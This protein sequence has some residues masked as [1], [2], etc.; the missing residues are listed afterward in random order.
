MVET[1]PEILRRA[2]QRDAMQGGGG[3]RSTAEMA[4]R[5]GV[6]TARAKR[7]LE[8]LFEAGE[9]ESY[10]EAPGREI[11]WSALRPTPPVGG[12]G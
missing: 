7:Q 3:T 11:L 5:L 9:I 6:T 10:Q 12:E 8:R 1:I 4:E 2:A